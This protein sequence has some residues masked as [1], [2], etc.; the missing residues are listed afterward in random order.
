MHARHTVG[1]AVVN[2]RYVT[3]AN[4]RPTASS[5]NVLDTS[6]TVMMNNPVTALVIDVPFPA[7]VNVRLATA[8]TDDLIAPTVM[9]DSVGTMVDNLIGLFYYDALWSNDRRGVVNFDPHARSV[10]YGRNIGLNWDNGNSG[11]GWRSL[12]LGL[13]HR[14]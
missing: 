1:T 2:M 12:H 8:L 9:H 7:A 11:N 14:E 10:H 5:V 13:S 4:G 3:A 6:A